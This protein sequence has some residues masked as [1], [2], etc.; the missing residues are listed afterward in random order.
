MAQPDQSNIPLNERV[1]KSERH[2]RSIVDSFFSEPLPDAC[3]TLVF[4]LQ[5]AQ[6]N[7]SELS[8]FERYAARLLDEAH[9]E[10]LRQLCAHHTIEMGRLTS[11]HLAWMRF[12]ES[13]LS[14]ED[15]KLLLNVESVVN[16]LLLIADRASEDPEIAKTLESNDG[17]GLAIE[18]DWNNLRSVAD[19]APKQLAALDQPNP[20]F[21]IFEAQAAIGGEWDARTRFALG[22]ESIVLPFRLAYRF[23]CDVDSGVI[24][25][26]V[27]APSSSIFPSLRWNAQ[28][29]AWENVTSLVGW[30]KAATMLRLSALVASIAFGSGI[31]FTK[32]IVCM[33]NESLEGD[34][35]LCVDFSRIGFVSQTLPAIKRSEL[36]S[37]TTDENVDHLV[38][39]M[40]ATE[41]RIASGLDGKPLPVEPIKVTYPKRNGDV[42]ADTR[43]I[44]EPLRDMLHA[45]IVSDLDINHVE[46]PEMQNMVREASDEAGE[47]PTA[48]QLTL[49]QVLH[50]FTERQDPQAKYLYC[51]DLVSRALIGM[52]DSSN[53]RY[54]KYPDAAYEAR[55]KLSDL[56]F[57]AGNMDDALK[58]S[59]AM[60]EYAP[61]SASGYFDA[62]IM[63]FREERYDTACQ[64]LK[65]LLSF[66]NDRRV[67]HYAYYRLAYALFLLG[68][69]EASIAVYQLVINDGGEFAEQARSE[70]S[71]VVAAAHA[72]SLPSLEESL[73]LAMKH[74]VP[75][76]PTAATRSYLAKAAIGLTDAKLFNVAVPITL[77]VAG[78]AYQD[79]LV[80]VVQSLASTEE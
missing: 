62:I 38:T 47:F 21:N 63:L 36:S 20:L 65:Q 72:N 26:D 32:C 12:D 61:T 29:R 6:Q 52:V 3:D 78:F 11:T 74:D 42:Y 10:R 80:S 15:I 73:E 4:R 69:H 56:Y 60:I 43:P 13:E 18:L 40:A 46:D 67:I 7:N 44:P 57:Y 70:L 68:Q 64:L 35:I 5:I 24:S 23:D 77:S 27:I 30:L 39:L 41:C 33:H 9:A 25:C 45:D 22:M 8:G 31:A 49:E 19:S 76:A 37:T 16:R 28:A 66:S 48:S 75:L 55:S 54:L 1:P 2:I 53:C 59:L 17:E 14:A 79:V 50:D 34:A 71:D 51:S 58:Q